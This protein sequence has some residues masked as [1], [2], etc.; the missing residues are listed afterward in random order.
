MVHQYEELLAIN[1]VTSQFTVQ[2]LGLGITFKAFRGRNQLLHTRQRFNRK[3]SEPCCTSPRTLPEHNRYELKS[4]ESYLQ[5]DVAFLPYIH[6]DV[7]PLPRDQ[8]LSVISSSLLANIWFIL[9]EGSTIQRNI[10]K[11]SYCSSRHKIA[12]HHEISLDDHTLVFA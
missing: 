5:S 8:P 3:C 11:E 10:F 9:E 1:M 6:P 4:D 2:V 7:H 12:I